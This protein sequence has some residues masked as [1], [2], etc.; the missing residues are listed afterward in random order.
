MT[1]T[2]AA[3]APQ[4]DYEQMPGGPGAPLP[5][6]QLAVSSHGPICGNLTNLVQGQAGLTDRDIKLMVEGGFHTV[7]SIAYS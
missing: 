6:A 5:I 2:E 4:D 1:Q 3:E 7:E